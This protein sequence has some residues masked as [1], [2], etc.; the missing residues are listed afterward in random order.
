MKKFQDDRQEVSSIF[1]I[2]EKGPH[3]VTINKPVPEGQG[4]IVPAVKEDNADSAKRFDGRARSKGKQH[5]AQRN[6]TPRRGLP[7]LGK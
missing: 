1:D 7:S 6:G 5:A 3:L 2:A 4:K